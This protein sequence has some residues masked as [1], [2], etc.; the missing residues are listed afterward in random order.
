[1]EAA[2]VAAENS[3]IKN[4]AKLR[5]YLYKNPT[6]LAEKLAKYL[7]DDNGELLPPVKLKGK[8]IAYLYSHNDRKFIPAPKNAEYYLTPWVDDDPKV[9]YIY[10]HYNWMV[11]VIFKVNRDQ[12]QH[13]GF[14]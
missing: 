4:K 6:K 5:E 10:T 8:G 12:I 13:I 7:Q 2:M 1:M 9:C 14:N 3:E 11:G